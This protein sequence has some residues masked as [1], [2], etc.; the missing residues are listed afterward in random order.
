M[1]Q[2]LRLSRLETLLLLFPIIFLLLYET[3]IPVLSSQISKRS[4]LA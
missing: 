4:Q 1:L 3:V 2:V